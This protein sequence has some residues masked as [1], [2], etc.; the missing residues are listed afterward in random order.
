MITTMP[1]RKILLCCFFLLFAYFSF[2]GKSIFTDSI[3]PSPTLNA[4]SLSVDGPFLVNIHFSEPVNGL[5]PD[6]LFVDNGEVIDFFGEYRDYTVQI[7]P[8][9]AGLVR[10]SIP[11]NIT[12]DLAGNGNVP[13]GTLTVTFTD[14]DPPTVVL[15]TPS[16]MVDTVFP[17]QIEFSE[18][19]TGLSINDFNVSN[20]AGVDLTGSEN[21]YVLTVNPGAVGTVAI[22]LPSEVVQDTA[23]NLNL[24]SN[25]LTVNFAPFDI[26]PPTVVLEVEET[27]VTSAFSVVARFSETIEGLAAADFEITNG[28]GAGL[29]G[30]GSVYSINVT[31]TAEGEVRIRLPEA[32]VVDL[33]ENENISSNEIVVN[34]TIPDTDRPMVFLTETGAA[35]DEDIRELTIAFSEAVTALAPEDVQVT[36]G[37][38]LDFIFENNIYKVEI[39]AT[40]EGT[41]TVQVPENVVADNAGNGNLASAVYSW[42][43]TVTPLEEP[44]PDPVLNLNLSLLM[45]DISVVWETNTEE[46]NAYFEVWHGQDDINLSVVHTQESNNLGTELVN[47]NFLHN[48]QLFGTHFYFI[49]QYDLNGNYVDSEKKSIE[50]EYEG[51]T[52]L[53]YPNPASDYVMLN[54]TPYAGIRCEIMIYNQ[55][56]QIFFWETFEALPFEPVR[57]NVSGY[58]KGTYGIQ[59]W[60]KETTKLEEKF[61]IVR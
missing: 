54:T 48:P 19:V 27:E 22:F 14:E 43:Y 42:E 56:G 60:I 11:A 18:P 17:V 40:D 52:A 12:T 24:V 6:D 59:F 37:L 61:I 7:R 29:S 26:Q 39:I 49:R 53:I 5:H 31:P 41:V 13:S 46:E 55:L 28:T 8:L 23:G 20:G 44:Q 47:Y 33:F 32:T 58:E 38:V 10:F 15:S 57:L 4:A 3:P 30:N 36:N 2:A 25:F 1:L 21:S 16:L 9:A 50:L 51:T 34:Y 45:E 35:Q